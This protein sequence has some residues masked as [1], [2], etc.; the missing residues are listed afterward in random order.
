[1]TRKKSVLF[2][3]IHNSARSQMAEAFLREIGGDYFI[4]ASA[5][6]EAGCLN[7][8]VIKVMSEIGLDIRVQSTDDVNNVIQRGDRFDYVITVC[9]AAN[10]QR[11]PIIPGTTQTL[12]WS[13]EDPAVLAGDDE[14][15]IKKVRVVRERIREQVFAFVESFGVSIAPDS[16][17]DTSS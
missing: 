13:F 3:C 10:A 15:K 17:K 5:G 9:D 4:A 6:L 12:H 16:V 14:E 11:C 2:V 7:P 8:L 1:M